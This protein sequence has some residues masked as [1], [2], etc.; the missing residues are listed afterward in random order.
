MGWLHLGA[1]ASLGMAV[2]AAWLAAPAGQRSAA[3]WRL[4][5]EQRQADP[6]PRELTDADGVVVVPARPERA[7]AASVLTAE[8]L[9]RLA[10][11]RVT[12]VHRLA[13]DPRFSAAAEAAKAFGHFTEALPEELLAWRPDLVLTDPFTRAETQ[14]LL[15][16]A[17]V[18]VLRT[19][20]CSSLPELRDNL[21]RIG[22]SMALDA[23]VEQLIEAMDAA[24]TRVGDRDK[25][26]GPW[27]LLCLNGLLEA[28]GQGSLFDALAT[29]VGAI[30]VAAHHGVG[31]FR[32]L[33]DEEVLSWRP[34]GL[35]VAVD[36]GAG[37]PEWLR[38]HPALR[39]LPC[40]QQGRVARVPRALLATTS[41]HLADAAAF[42]A[43]T[44][45]AWG[46]R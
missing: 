21:R 12:A 26:A 43:A 41:H 31:P 4:P 45:D 16:R 15:H 20:P 17:S 1:A 23:E 39:L 40:V 9:L 36:P 38:Q 46:P 35:V 33:S 7:V 29:S 3:R 18:P 28:Y 2:M 42:L 19:G 32:R 30:N 24:L 22:Y 25:A 27:R 10:P 14:V 8:V 6:F 37:E 11:A 5:L 44:L 34:D 13:A